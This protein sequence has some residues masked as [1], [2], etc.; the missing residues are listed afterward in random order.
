MPDTYDLDESLQTI[1][2]WGKY[3]AAAYRVLVR[4]GPLEASDV[5]VRADIPQGRVY[6]ILNSLYNQDAVV[7]RGIQPTEYDAQSPR[8]LIEPNKQKFENMAVEAIEALE[9]AYS[10]NLETES[11]PAW[12]T[13]GIGDTSTK[14]RELFD[15]ADERIWILERSFWLS[16]PDTELLQRKAEAGVDVRIVGWSGRQGLREMPREVPGA[17]FREASEV[18]TSFYVSDDG[19][20]L[21]NL[22][23]GETGLLFHDVAT[24]TIFTQ[25]FESIYRTAE[26]VEL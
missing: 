13:T 7:K 15:E 22:N 2:D 21:I 20:V 18:E 11:H 9:P 26:E 24:A 19:T 1:M 4:Y 14:A 8:K 25:H 5:V 10:M 23:Q 16:S 12:V 17:E 3:E 6:D